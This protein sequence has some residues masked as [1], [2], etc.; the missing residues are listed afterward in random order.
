[1]KGHEETH[2]T[3]LDHFQGMVVGHTAQADGRVHSR[4][5]GRLILGAT[6]QNGMRMEGGLG[7]QH[8]PNLFNECQIW[9]YGCIHCQLN[10]L[11]PGC[12]HK[13][14][15]WPATSGWDRQV[16]PGRSS[17]PHIPHSTTHPSGPR[18][19]SSHA[20]TPAQR[21]LRPSN[22]WPTEVWKPLMCKAVND[23]HLEQWKKR[24]RN[25]FCWVGCIWKLRYRLFL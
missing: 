11:K 22:T 17:P 15:H 19:P 13:M 10:P 3:S 23:I 5:G 1:M 7:S 4:C 8:H 25:G 20:S 6:G 16:G 18:I 2:P 21:T 24:A 9:V 12:W 14:I